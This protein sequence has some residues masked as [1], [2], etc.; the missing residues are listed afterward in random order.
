MFGLII[1][2]RRQGFLDI[3]EYRVGHIQVNMIS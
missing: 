1:D 2:D 3:L